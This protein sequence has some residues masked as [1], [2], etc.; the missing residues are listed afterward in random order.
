MNNEY[1]SR[2]YCKSISCCVQSAIMDKSN[3]YIT[4]KELKEKMCKRCEAYKFHKWL[5]ANNYIIF[6]E[7]NNNG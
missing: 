7:I 3:S 5:K 4:V 1:Q 2:E 6:K